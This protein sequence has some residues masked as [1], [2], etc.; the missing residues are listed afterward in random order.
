MSSRF[1]SWNI[2]EPFL[3]P[4]SLDEFV[5]DDHLAVFVRDLVAGELDLSSIY[6]SYHPSMGHPANNPH[7]MMALLLYSYCIGNFSSR[8]IAKAC[9]ERLDYKVIVGMETPDHRRICEFR[10]RHTPALKDLF[11]QVL[12]LCRAAGLVRM[13]H[14]SLDGTKIRAN[15]SK[16]KAMSYG[17][18]D[19]AQ[20]RLRKQVKEWLSTAAALDDAEDTEFGKDCRGDELPAWVKN[21]AERIKRIRGAK[22]AL[23]DRAKEEV[24]KSGDD[25]SPPKPAPK[26]QYNFTDPESRVMKTPDG[27]QQCYN[28]QA[29]VDADSQVIVAAQV[30]QQGNDKEQLEPMIEAIKENNGRNPDELSADNGYCSEKNLRLLHRRRIAGYIATGRQKHGSASATGKSKMENKWVRSMQMKLR[31]GG[32]RSRYRLRKQTVEPV[33]GQIKFGRGFRQFLRR[34]TANV[35]AEWQLVCATHN[36]LKLHLAYG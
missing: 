15:A 32:F 36:I 7:M 28:A 8:K 2:Q 33:F 30:T 29:A 24:M 3:F 22:K 19:Q 35:S 1:R 17:R 26:S 20:K 21:K 11:Q 18:M 9:V 16:H 5:P 23:E 31:R 34:G 10:K 4:P 6:A 25:D 27:F 13:G 12:E 14:V